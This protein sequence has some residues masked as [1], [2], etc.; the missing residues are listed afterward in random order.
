MT[1]TGFRSIKMRG[2]A[3]GNYV[4]IVYRRWGSSYWDNSRT[5]CL[6]NS[7]DTE[8]GFEYVQ[9]TPTCPFCIR[10]SS[11]P[12]EIRTMLAEKNGMPWLADWMREHADV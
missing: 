9:D 11:L 7:A 6:M 3:E 12:L 2:W 8:H 1:T 4:H 10:D 5:A